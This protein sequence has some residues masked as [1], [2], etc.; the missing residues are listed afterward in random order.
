MDIRISGIFC[1]A[2][3]TGG[4]TYWEFPAGTASR[5]G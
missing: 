2:G 5:D 1:Y 4:S 3:I